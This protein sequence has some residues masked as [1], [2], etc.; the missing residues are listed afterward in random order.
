MKATLLATSGFT[1]KKEYPLDEGKTYLVGRSREAA[2]IVKD[3]LASRNHCKVSQTGAEEWTIADLGSSNGTY[4][5]RQRITTRVL[6]HG[7][8]IQIGKA[9]LEF[10]L[11]GVTT[12]PTVITPPTAEELAAAPP[13]R[14]AVVEAAP[15][16]AAPPTA[17]RPGPQPAWRPPPPQPQPAPAQRAPAAQPPPA[18]PPPVPRPPTAAHPAAPPQPAQPQK[19]KENL[20]EDVR[21]LFEFLD[22]VGSGGRPTDERPAQQKEEEEELAVVEVVEEPPPVRPQ[23]ERTRTMKHDSVARRAPPEPPLFSL[24]D[25]VAAKEPLRKKTQ[26]QPPAPPQPPRPP[27]APQPPRPPQQQAPPPPQAGD[28]GGLMAFLKKKKQQP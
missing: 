28:Q 2:V 24:L 18:A 27:Q 10:R 11:L 7:D 4:V 14:A 5:N 21:G 20:D 19:P 17:P 25:E 15:A 1:D 9:V 8:I 23:D 26:P 16:P 12:A 3:K 22:K 6:R 13:R